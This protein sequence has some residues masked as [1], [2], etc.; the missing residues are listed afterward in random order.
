MIFM[1]PAERRAVETAIVPAWGGTATIAPSVDSPNETFTDEAA[2][3]PES[4]GR[5]PHRGVR[6]RPDLCRDPKHARVGA[7]GN[8]GREPCRLAA[9]W[10]SRLALFAR[11]GTRGVAPVSAAARPRARERHHS[12]IG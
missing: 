7:G 5:R 4:S 12:E 3:S 10:P 11:R 6:R 2:D 9:V 1:S 8:R